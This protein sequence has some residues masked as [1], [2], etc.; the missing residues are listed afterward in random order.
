MEQPDQMLITPTCANYE[1]SRYLND[2]SRTI[3]FRPFS[4]FAGRSR[5]HVKIYHSSVKIKYTYVGYHKSAPK[6][7]E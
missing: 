3:K 6:Y 4:S 5:T 1:T 7:E 2:I